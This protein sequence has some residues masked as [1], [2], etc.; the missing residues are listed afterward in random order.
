MGLN[1]SDGGQRQEQARRE[2]FAFHYWFMAKFTSIVSEWNSIDFPCVA[3]T[4]MLC[5]ST[6]GRYMWLNWGQPKEEKLKYKTKRRVHSSATSM[7]LL[8]PISWGTVA[9]LLSTPVQLP[10]ALLDF[11]AC[12]STVHFQGQ[13]Y[14]ASPK[15]PLDAGC[16]WAPVCAHSVCLC[17]AL[18]QTSGAPKW[19]RASAL[20][21]HSFQS[22]WCEVHQ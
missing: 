10:D 3:F 8:W 7:L 5:L 17:G 6:A 22:S 1:S 20:M 14:P 21:R 2:H 13:G 12:F 18:R 19:R 15:E 4:Y 9:I 11:W 16:R